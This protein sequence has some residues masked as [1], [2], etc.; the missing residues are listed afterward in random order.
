M[1][2]VTRYL[3]R[4]VYIAMLAAVVVL[5]F[6][7]LSNVLVRYMHFAASGALSS[8]AVKIIMLLQIPILSAIL[9]PASL[10]LGILLAYGRLYADSEMIIF[11]V[12]G[13]DPKRLLTTNLILALIIILLVATLSL[14]INP[15]VYKYYDHINSGAT[16]L[17][18]DMVK[19]GSFNNEIAQ[20]KW[21]FYVETIS[22]D[23]KYFYN[24]FA[25][26]QT[27][28]SSQIGEQNLCV[29]TAKSAYQ[30]QGDSNGNEPY[31]ILK[32]GYRYVGTP[33]QKDYEI[34]KYDEYG[35][36]ISPE[37]QEWHGDESSIPTMKLLQAKHNNLAAAE[38]QWRISLPL[39]TFILT[40]IGIPLSKVKSKR[41]RYAQLIPAILLYVVYANF[42]FLA[43]AWIK[44]GVLSPMLGV[45]WVHGLMLALAIFL[46]GRQLGWWRIFG[47]K[48]QDV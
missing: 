48:I 46:I 1:K 10:F 15:K 11:T 23:K 8:Q 21:V 36:K 16:S 39:S 40:L 19:P 13:M 4:E 34:T 32:D 27:N 47:A 18:L 38:L 33:G 6:I 26:E 17:V 29:L 9:L 22:H 3:I 42:L 28:N 37:T 7:F 2:I 30:Q 35:I 45:W 31:I 43:R 5:L 20:G 24:V 25:V 41:G 44:R 12:C 14:W